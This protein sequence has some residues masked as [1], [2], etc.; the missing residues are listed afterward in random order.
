VMLI[1]VA[2]ALAAINWIAVDCNALTV[3]HFP[4]TPQETSFLPQHCT[5]CTTLQEKR[6]IK[7]CEII[8]ARRKQQQQQQQL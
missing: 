4:I 7:L 3:Y 1:M 6:R 2:V 8:R 5:T